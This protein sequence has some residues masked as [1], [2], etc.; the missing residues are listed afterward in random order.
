MILSILMIKIKLNIKLIVFDYFTFINYYNIKMNFDACVTEKVQSFINHINSQE[1]KFIPSLIL[2]VKDLGSLVTLALIAEI[3]KIYPDSINKIIPVRFILSDEFGVID[4]C[5]SL[6]LECCVIDIT[7][8]VEK[9]ASIISMCYRPDKHFKKLKKDMTR[10]CLYYIAIRNKGMVLTSINKSDL[11]IGKFSKSSDKVGDWNLIGDL[12]NVQIIELAKYFNIPSDLINTQENLNYNYERSINLDYKFVNNRF[13]NKDYGTT[14]EKK[15]YNELKIKHIHKHSFPHN[16]IAKLDKSFNEQRHSTTYVTPYPLTNELKGLLE[17]LRSRNRFNVHDWL[18]E[19]ILQ[20]SEY[21]KMNGLLN[22]SVVILVS[23][24]VDS[25][26]T[27]A[28]VKEAKKRNKMLA[29][30]Q[31]IP[32]AVPISSTFLVQNRAYENC[33]TQE[34]PCFTVDLTEVHNSLC[35]KISNIMNFERSEYA[36]GC[37]KSS[38]RATVAYY[39]ARLNNGIVLGTGNKS[40]DK[41]LGYFSKSGDGLVDLQLI[42]DIYKS[43]VYE[44][45]EVLGTVKTI[46]EAVPTADLWSGQSD[47]EELKLSYDFVELYLRYLEEPETEQDLLLESLS[48][49]TRE[50]FERLRD[51]IV[52]INK[53]NKHKF[54]MPMLI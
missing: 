15:T 35:N 24:G 10:S 38:L 3:K 37:F 30:L 47:E 49:E 14:Q 25:A 31:I 42:A 6:N 45:A 13:D 22:G 2:D 1:L 17:T 50:E 51:V 52:E 4:Y 7:E 9:E 34:L 16:L 11:D 54:T 23:G 20:F 32:I 19:R 43:D 39:V 40:E 18:F 21:M 12:T 33:K 36:D 26:A 8:E 41:Y 48:L 28:I 53:I 27:L 44:V 29:N 46:L 5:K